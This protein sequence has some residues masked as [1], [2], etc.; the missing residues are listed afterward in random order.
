MASI[1]FFLK[2]PTKDRPTPVI[3]RVAFAGT[4]T[5][6]YTGLSIEPRKWIQAAQLVQVRGNAQAGRVNDALAAIRTSLENCFLECVAAGAVPTAERLRQAIE[7]LAQEEAVAVAAPG[8][9]APPAPTTLLAA[10]EQ[11]NEHQRVRFS[12]A[13]I[14]TNI[15][16]L[17]HLQRYQASTGCPLALDTLT[18]PVFAERY[19]R[20]LSSVQ[21]LTDNSIAKNLTRLKAFLRF[22]HAFGLTDKPSY[23][24]LTWKKQEPDILTLTAEEVH[25]LEQLPLPQQPALANARDLF[26]L[27]CYTGLRFSDLVNLRPEHLQEDRLRLRVSKTRELLMVPLRPEARALLLRLFAGTIHVISNQKLNAYLKAVGQLAG[28]DALVE[29][30]RYRAGKRESETFRKWELLTCH[31]GRRTFVTLALE[32]GLRPELVMKI[33]GHRSFQA[34]KRYVNITEQAVEREFMQVYGKPA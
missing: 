20:F 21:R 2:E 14:Q 32:R 7:P 12:R 15:T 31:C 1:T 34:F 30:T 5:K 4:K 17:H 16:L 33:T 13:T 27:S 8:A 29:R 19:C 3:A 10:F 6:V 24:A 26:L 11:W 22:A 18:S 25:G 23:E 9:D 28:L